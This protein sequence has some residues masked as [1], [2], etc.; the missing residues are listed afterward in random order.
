MNLSKIIL[1]G[2]LFSSILFTSECECRCECFEKKDINNNSN[3]KV[4]ITDLKP[5]KSDNKNSIVSSKKHI[6][7]NIYYIDEEG[8]TLLHQ[9]VI[10]KDIVRVKELLKEDLDVNH[11]NNKG[12]TPLHLATINNSLNIVKIL[13][14]NN[15]K[16]TIFDIYGYSPLYYANYLKFFEIANYLKYYGASVE[17][18]KVSKQTKLDNFISEFNSED[19]F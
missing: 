9:A 4:S 18:K 7:K 6:E 17:I 8:N 16:L 13:I 12:Q 15:A 19:E 14:K 11:R 1:L 2:I 3:I 10:D 5:I